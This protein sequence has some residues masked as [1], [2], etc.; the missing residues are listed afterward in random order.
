MVTHRH[1]EYQAFCTW[2]VYGD[3]HT[4]GPVYPWPPHWPQWV[5]VA[6]ELDVVLVVD[7]L[8]EV[9]DD[10]VLVTRVVLVVLVLVVLLPLLPP[11]RTLV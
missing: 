4:V 8:V 6:P 11:P 9:V 2:Q 1:C 5:C 10:L 3:A 7:V